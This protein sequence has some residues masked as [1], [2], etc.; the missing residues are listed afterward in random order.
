MIWTLKSQSFA[1]RVFVQFISLGASSHFL[2][3]LRYTGLFQHKGLRFGNGHG[4]H[5]AF[6]GT[7][8]S[9]IVCSCGAITGMEAR[10][11]GCKVAYVYFRGMDGVFALVNLHCHVCVIQGIC[12]LLLIVYILRK[13]FDDGLVQ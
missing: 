8:H 12:C 10:L 5:N 4:L 2:L 3:R 11:Y 13:F 1:F 6:P 9:G 7:E